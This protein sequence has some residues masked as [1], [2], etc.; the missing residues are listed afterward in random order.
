MVLEFVRFI[1]IDKIVNITFNKEPK[2][3]ER[4]LIMK[5]QKKI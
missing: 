3:I 5:N 4:Y 1:E 2:I